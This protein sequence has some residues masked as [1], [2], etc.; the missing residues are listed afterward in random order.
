M[1]NHA[2]KVIIKLLTCYILWSKTKGTV[3]FVI[4]RRNMSCS[5]FAVITS[6]GNL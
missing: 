2:E 6:Y 1:N 3:T 4:G 5:V